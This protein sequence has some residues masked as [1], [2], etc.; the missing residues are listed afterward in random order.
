VEV[1]WSVTGG[2]ATRGDGPPAVGDD[3]V[4]PASG[5]LQF[6]P[7]EPSKTIQVTIVND[8]DVEPNETL[9]LELGMPTGG[10]L[11]SPKI[12]ILTI[13]DND[14]KGTIQ[15][16]APLTNVAEAD[17]AATI[18]VIRTGNLTEPATVEWAI[19]G[20]SAT[21]G[22]SPGAG[23]DYVA[24]ASGVLSFEAGKATPT[25]PLTVPVSFDTLVEGNESV[26]LVLQSPSTGWALGT[27]SNATLSLVEGTIQFSGL[28]LLVSESSGSRTMT[29]TRSGLTTQAVTVKYTV[30]P[31]GTATPASTPIACS[32]GSDYRPV[33]GTLVFSPGQ[34]SKTFSVP[35]CGDLVVEGSETV[36]ISLEVES[37]P[38][39][40]GP[41]GD[42][43]TLTITENDLAGVIQFS[44]LTYSASEGQNGIATVTRTSTGLGAKVH[45][46]VVGGTAQ[47]GV[48]FT[49][50]T[51]GDLEFAN[52]TSKP[53]V[54]PLVNT[55]AADGPRT[56][57]VELSN[58]LPLG[59]A[60]LGTR[61]L[62]TLTLNDNEPTLRLNS[63]SY[64]VGEANTTNTTFN[65]TVL[66]AGPAGAPLTV[67]LHPQQN[68]TATGDMC[69]ENGADFA[70]G[71]IPVTLNANQTFKTVPVTLCGD[72]RAEGLERFRL[73]LQNPV[74]ATLATPNAATVS[75]TDNELGGTLRWSAADASG[76]E[77]TT[78]VLTVTRTGGTASDVTVEFQAHDGDDDT[79]GADAVAGVDYEVVTVTPVTFDAGILTQT[80][81]IS[82]LPRPD[83]QGPR[84]FRVVL[85]DAA[86]GA[87]LGSPATVTVWIL[88]PS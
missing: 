77:G 88:D 30:G 47:H 73:A 34:P 78:L 58:P 44:S 63:A 25:T 19:T 1:P 83:T 22:D 4:V 17:V 50:P 46:A 33:T 10:L 59:L 51:E 79:P 7:N 67:D 53:I 13:V 55:T 54:I 2:T 49:G 56:I 61:V 15:F 70:D 27:V 18:P 68:D 9:I 62:A 69:G 84:S 38:A 39:I 86:G 11:G 57:L 45:W 8:T 80:V 3:V 75:I 60:S 81:E 23:V 6:G 43:A 64:V 85:H 87:A 52:L 31:A 41:S 71:V 21:R 35:L 66:R 28:P 24:P 76:E 16:S 5:V 82:L 36:D 42:T 65:V 20:G 72:T 48:D 29:V 14:R 40:I 32:P 74:G 12:A 26:E 37:G